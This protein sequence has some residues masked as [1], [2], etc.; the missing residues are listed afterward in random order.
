MKRTFL[1]VLTMLLLLGSASCAK[2]AND[3][4]LFDRVMQAD[5]ALKAAKAGGAVVF[6]DLRCTAGQEIWDKFYADTRAGQAAQV[7]CAYYYTLDEKGVSEEYYEAEK[8]NYPK[9][10]FYLLEFDGKAYTIRT[11]DCTEKEATEPKS[12]PYLVHYSG[13]APEGALFNH[14]DYYVLVEDESISLEEIQ[15]GYSSSQMGD[16]VPH[17]FVYHNLVD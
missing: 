11:R 8:N 4:A 12:F 15:R 1:F 7:V 6:D 9:L 3:P 10:F 14:Y 2:G 13:D 16:W 5:E 17:H